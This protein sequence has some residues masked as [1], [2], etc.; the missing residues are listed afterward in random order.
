MRFACLHEVLEPLVIDRGMDAFAA[1]LF[2]DGDFSPHSFDHD[3]DLVLGNRCRVAC[4]GLADQ[5]S[6]GLGGAGRARHCGG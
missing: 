5:S 4:L 3:A 2:G 1:P 6:C